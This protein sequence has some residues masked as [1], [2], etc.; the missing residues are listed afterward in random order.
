MKK[1]LGLTSKI[2]IGILLGA[3]LGLI[4]KGVPNGTI[5]NTILLDGVLKVMG[6]G[7][8]NSI[9]MLVVPLVF[10]SLVCGSS[11]MG[12]VKKLGRIGIRTFCFYLA[13]TAIAISLALGVGKLINPGVGLD[14]SNLITQAPTIGESKPLVEVILSII[15]TNPIQSLASG[16]MLQIIMFSLL[17]GVSMS[18]VGKKA[19]PLRKLFESANEVCMKMVSIIMLVAPYGVFALIANTFATTG[20]DAIFSLLKYM[21]AVSL[22]LVLQVVIVYSGMV[23]IFTGLKLKPFFKKFAGVAAVT[24]STASSN[25]ALPL[26]IESM[27]ELGVDNSVASFTLPLG[28]TINMDGTAIM[29]G[30]ACIFIAQLYGIDL[31]ISSFLTI[32]LTAT[33]ASVGTAGVPGV[34]M[35]TLSMVL[36]S[37]G[38]PLEGIGL[39]MGVDRLLDMARTTVNVMGD[40]ACTLVVSNKEGELD[41]SMYY[42]EFT[43][44]SEIGA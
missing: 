40:C 34:G 37:V 17:L 5:K 23:K 33:L 26:T 41:K 35:I 11:S 8:I 44:N 19:D 6:S 30:V 7:F 1:K 4:L 14:M 25:A 20:F 3:V 39:I 22:A 28:A 2:F 32:I 21:F 9:K 43:Q 12:D 31:G 42:R 10:I 16:E 36:T 15:P 38:L 27:E 24:F 29:Q 13:T 18:V